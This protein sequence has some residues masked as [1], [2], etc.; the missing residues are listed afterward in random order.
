MLTQDQ[1]DSFAASGMIR[2]R[3]M[4]TEKAELG[5]ER[6]IRVCEKAGSWRDGKWELGTPLEIRKLIKRIRKSKAIGDLTTPTLYNCIL[7]LVDGHEVYRRT[8]TAELLLSLPHDQG[9]IRSDLDWHLDAPRLKGV[10]IAGVQ[11]FTFLDTVEAGGGAPV[12]VA[13]SHRLNIKG[14]HRRNG[15]RQE[16]EQTT[17]FSDLFSKDLTERE[18][19]VGK[20][21]RVDGT[22]LEVVELIG[23]PGD[24]YLMDLWLLHTRFPNTGDAARMML[25]QRFVLQSV[26]NEIGN[27]AWFVR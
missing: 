6:I 11:V 19:I 17:F 25:T 10:R 16:L 3:G 18:Y 27:L 2:L 14:N 12:A 13:G 4:L 24:V 1:K 9:R 7:Q 23:E 21:G 20:V 22:R 15:L 5:R 8:E 26:R